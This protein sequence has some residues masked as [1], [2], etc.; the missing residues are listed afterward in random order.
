MP[1]NRQNE[2]L[3]DA[4]TVLSVNVRSYYNGRHAAIRDN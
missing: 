3:T 4:A 1:V 2:I